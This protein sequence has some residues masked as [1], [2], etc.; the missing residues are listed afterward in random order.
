M[1]QSNQTPLLIKAMMALCMIFFFVQCNSDDPAREAAREAALKSP[2]LPE[3]VAPAPSNVPNQPVEVGK[4]PMRISSEKA[5][6]GTETC[7]SVT[8]SQFNEIV[9]MQYTMK[10]DPKVLQYKEV[11]N[12]GL[13]GL[14]V[15]NFGPRAVDQGILAYSWFDPKVQGITKPDGFKLYDVCFEA[16]GESGKTT[17][18]SFENEPVVI[19]ITNSASQFLGVEGVNGKVTVE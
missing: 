19:E 10:W 11:K 1:K 17:A 2:K 4:L 8:A 18:F 7:L 14:T 6:R 13:P 15:T 16:I 12:F 5:A 9:S 3:G